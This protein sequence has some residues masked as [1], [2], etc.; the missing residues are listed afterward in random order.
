MQR[1]KRGFALVLA[2]VLVL[3]VLG[4]SG[5]YYA[6]QKQKEVVPPGK[7]EAKDKAGEDM[8]KTESKTH[9]IEMTAAG[10]SPKELEIK[11]G[12]IVEFVNKDSSKHWPASGVH[13][14]HLICPGFDSKK[15]MG[16]GET[17]SF[18]FSEAKTCPF[19][20]HLSPNL[21]GKIEVEE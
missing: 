21:F 20:D 1:Q 11:K 18:T 2:I 12:D 6:A 9:K 5:V 4:G 16:A 7:E 17:Y 13:P 19:H 15:R 14:A 10:F 8:M 3:L